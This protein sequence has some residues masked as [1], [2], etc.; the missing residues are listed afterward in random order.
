MIGRPVATG[1]LGGNP[2]LSNPKAAEFGKELT[3]RLVHFARNL[4]YHL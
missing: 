4:L 3:L 2:D 1:H